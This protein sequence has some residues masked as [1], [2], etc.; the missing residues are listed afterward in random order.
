LPSR[1]AIVRQA[2]EQQ[3]LED[4]ALEDGSKGRGVDGSTEDGSKGRGVDGSTEELV[5]DDT[6]RKF[7]VAII[8]R[9]NVGKS[10]LLNTLLNEERCIVDDIPGT[11]RDPIDSLVEHNGIEYRFVDTAGIRKRARTTERVDKFSVVASL[12]H[13]E[14]AD[15]VLLLLD[16]QT[17]PT[18]Q[19]AHVAGYAFEKDRAI[20]VLANKWDEGQKLYTKEEFEHRLEL[21]MNYLNYCPVLYVSGK[22]GKNVTKIFDVI[23]SLRKQYEIKITTGA[24]NRAFE[25][26]INNHPLP[27]YKGQEIK[28][29]YATQVHSSP[30]SFIVFCNYPK[31]VHFSYQRYLIN[32]LRK[33]FKL[34]EVP[35]RVIFKGRK[36]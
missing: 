31:Q 2:K 26:I 5:R 10:T 36:K 21:K 30:P 8:G 7:S 12:K 16:S 24:L 35:I 19:D 33:I 20:I 22:T 27:I 34:H 17:G 25:H 11:T 14:S 1:R 6:K 13:I 28:M 23:E 18:E 9:P 4:G 29:Y 3:E 15:L 32:S